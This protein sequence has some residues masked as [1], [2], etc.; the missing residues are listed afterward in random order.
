MKDSCPIY[1]QTIS[2]IRNVQFRL[3]SQ[4]LV[5]FLSMRDFNFKQTGLNKS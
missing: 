3:F 1:F 2:L 5:L 4:F